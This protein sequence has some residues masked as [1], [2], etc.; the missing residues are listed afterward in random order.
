[1]T[2][3]AEKSEALLR[4]IVTLRYQNIA[5]TGATDLPV[6]KIHYNE[7]TLFCKLVIH[8]QWPII[9]DEFRN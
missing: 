1:M 2:G 9:G 5:R 8:Q 6:I 4:V 7:I 3:D